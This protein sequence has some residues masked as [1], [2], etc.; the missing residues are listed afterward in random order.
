M[1]SHGFDILPPPR[2]PTQLY[3]F[4]LF[5]SF[6]YGPCNGSPSSPSLFP[7]IFPIIVWTGTLPAPNVPS[8]VRAQCN[9]QNPMHKLSILSW[10][11]SFHS[12][13]PP[14]Q[15]HSVTINLLNSPTISP[16]FSSLSSSYIPSPFYDPFPFQLYM[17]S[18]F[19]ANSLFLS[20]NIFSFPSSLFGPVSFH[21]FLS[22]HSNLFHSKFWALS[23]LL[24]STLPRHISF[25]G[26]CLSETAEILQRAAAE[27]AVV[28][29]L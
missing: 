25:P 7:P 4:S 10:L 26:C 16:S 14:Q 8:S 22:E 1:D 5:N 21:S 2:N 13:E 6:H 11:P 15:P 29:Q 23:F 19:Q 20:I 3:C 17:P 9:L 12:S 27:V 24:A 18:T 28:Q